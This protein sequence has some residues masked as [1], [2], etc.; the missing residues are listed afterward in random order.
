MHYY[1]TPWTW[2][3]DP[4]MPH[5]HVP[6]ATGLIDLRTISQ[7]NKRG[8]A[9]EGF[10]FAEFDRQ[11]DLRGAQYLGNDFDALRNDLWS[12]LT[13]QSDPI[14]QSAPSPLMPGRDMRMYLHMGGTRMEKRLKPKLSPEWP[15]VLAGL[16]EEYKKIRAEAM[17]EGSMPSDHHRRVVDAWQEKYRVSDY[18]EFIPAGYPDESPLPHRTKINE[19]FN[20][21]DS[22]TLG[23]DLTWTE[24]EG[25]TDIVGNKAR[26]A[27][28]GTWSS[29]RADTDLSSSD[30][31]SEIAMHLGASGTSAQCMSTCRKDGTATITQY[32]G[33]AIGDGDWFIGK[34]TAGAFA[35]IA[36]PF[37]SAISLGDL[38]RL[39]VNGSSLSLQHNGSSIGGVTDTSITG[40][41]RCGFSGRFTGGSTVEFDFFEAADLVGGVGA[42]GGR[43]IAI[44]IM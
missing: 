11:I 25:D 22:D 7:M 44:G 10:A 17:G 27:L 20:T 43:L 2:D 18:R 3:A 8:G 13:D 41:L 35:S 15:F 32:Y 30:H 5:W 37:S 16:H 23:P 40:N 33:Q 9:P 4:V 31:Y 29:A 34:R 12:R 28:T 14:G 38:N 26:T 39:S 42:G 36:G 6:D 19:S 1:L 24:L 21:A